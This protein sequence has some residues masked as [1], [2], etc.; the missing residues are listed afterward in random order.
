M[1]RIKIALSAVALIA[2][3][4]AALPP[5]HAEGLTVPVKGGSRM[6]L[7]A[8]AAHRLTEAG[9]ALRAGGPARLTGRDRTCV[10]LPVTRGAVSLD[11]AKG[12]AA[13]DGSIIFEGR[14]QSLTL[15]D[16]YSHPGRTRTSAEATVGRG[17]ARPSTCWTTR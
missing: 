16:L 12:G 6:C 17:R 8:P 4:A 7:T 2:V 3:V 13:M 9:I 5:A 10:D 1:P 11:L 14:R 15:S